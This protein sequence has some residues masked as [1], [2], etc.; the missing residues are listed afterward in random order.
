MIFSAPAASRR[1][2]QRNMLPRPLTI[3]LLL[4]VACGGSP[5]PAPKA[6]LDSELPPAEPAVAPS[7]TTPED[8]ADATCNKWRNDVHRKLVEEI[9]GA[10]QELGSPLIGVGQCHYAKSGIWITGLTRVRPTKGSDGKVQ[11][12]GQWQIVYFDRE[13]GTTALLAPSA[14]EGLAA[15]AAEDNFRGGERELWVTGWPFDFDGDGTQELVVS[16]SRSDLGK[17]SDDVTKIFTYRNGAI[18]FYDT[19][20]KLPILAVDDKN[21]DG[22]PDLVAKPFASV[23]PCSENQRLYTDAVFVAVSQPNGTFS[24]DDAYAKERLRKACPAAPASMT[25]PDSDAEFAYRLHT[26]VACGRVWGRPETELVAG[27]D[28]ALASKHPNRTTC[29]VSRDDLVRFARVTPPVTLK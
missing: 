28:A 23:D 14:G 21:G 7:A 29:P 26:N 17:R 19:G 1:T 11:L 2:T 5:E 24:W 9:P 18:G 20:S 15:A 4:V 3:S 6:G 22:R 12:E 13:K 16:W 10:V 27:I 25:P 8:A